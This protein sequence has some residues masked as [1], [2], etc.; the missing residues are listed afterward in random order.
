MNALDELKLDMD[1]ATGKVVDKHRLRALISLLK[2]L[3]EDWE[4]LSGLRKALRAGP[5]TEQADIDLLR[6]VLEWHME[7][8]EFIGALINEWMR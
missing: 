1:V 7:N 4:D 8:E 6:E 3:D 2:D 5:L